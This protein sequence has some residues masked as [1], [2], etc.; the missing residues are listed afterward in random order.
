MT[1]KHRTHDYSSLPE[2]KA[3]LDNIEERAS[4][5]EILPICKACPL[6]CKTRHALGFYRFV[7]GT[8]GEWRKG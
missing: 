7:C 6:D 3:T 4:Q 5:F 1:N 2:K 8:R